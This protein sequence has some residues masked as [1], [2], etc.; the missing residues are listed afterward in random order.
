MQNEWGIDTDS[1]GYT[2]GG[3]L[4]TDLAKSGLLPT[5]YPAL[6]EECGAIDGHSAYKFWITPDYWK[7]KIDRR[8]DKYLGPRNTKPPVATFGNFDGA[9][10]IA[11]VEGYKKALSFHITTGL[12]TI[13]LDGCWGFGEIVDDD[14]DV[15]I[16]AKQLNN[17]ILNVLTPGQQHLVILDGDIV[18]NPNVRLAGAT[19]FALL[20]NY[21][22]EPTFKYLGMHD[23]ERLG[24]DDWFVLNY[25]TDRATW[26]SKEEMISIVM[27]KL[28]NLDNE[29]LVGISAK[30]AFGDIASF[31]SAHTDFTDRG[32]ATLALMLFGKDNLRYMADLKRWYLW[33][34]SEWV[35]VGEKPTEK[36]NV[37]AFWHFRRAEMN[38]KLANK[39]LELE[40][41]EAN[42]EVAT[43]LLKTVALHRNFGNRHS[44]LVPRENIVKELK[45]RAELCIDSSVFDVTIHTLGVLNGVLDLKTGELCPAEHDDLIIRTANASYFAEMPAHIFD[46]R[47]IQKFFYD[48]TGTERDVSGVSHPDTEL[49]DYLQMRLGVGLLGANADQTFDIFTG[50]GANGKSALINLLLHTLGLATAG[51]YAVVVKPEMML[52][53]TRGGNDSQNASP[54]LMATKGARFAFCSETPDNAVID[55]QVLKQLTGGEPV[56]C[57]GLYGSATV[58][59][60]QFNIFMSTNHLPGIKNMDAAVLDRLAIFPFRVRWKRPN[61]I[62]L[63]KYEANV[64]VA[65]SWWLNAGTIPGVRDFVLW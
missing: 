13:V 1:A 20:K 28:H 51:G 38:S 17:E 41:D 55:D 58:L 30:H 4:L 62:N 63:D 14:G 22:V 47:D 53:A 21:C 2:V 7:L 48:I 45:N 26:P 10:L 32:A 16:K 37:V 57:R 29:I 40:L 11:T 24:Y 25:G 27:G 35:N 19:Y 59:T 46:G 12:P 23:G 54:F 43:E 36:L 34:K 52:R 65:D 44:D 8:A 39:M 60:P 9:P 18:S 64:P 50:I 56:A 5:D 6:P 15:L 42:L 49:H 61:G 31:N 3:F 33:D